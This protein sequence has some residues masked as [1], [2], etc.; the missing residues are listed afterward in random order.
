MWETRIFSF[1]HIIFCSVRDKFC[2]IKYLM[3]CL[4]MLSI[5][6]DLF[7]RDRKHCGKRRKRWLQAIFIRVITSLTQS[8]LL[9]TL[10]K[11]ALENTVGKG[12]NA[13]NQYFLLFPQSFLLYQR[14]ILSFHQCF[15]CCLQFFF[16]LV[17]SEICR[18]VKVK[19]QDCVVHMVS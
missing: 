5:S 13:G 2:L 8:R 11:K 18:L 9:I 6:Q 15:I 1:S 17:T 19:S 14:E 4:Q 16:N 3:R 12:E 7:W 10:K